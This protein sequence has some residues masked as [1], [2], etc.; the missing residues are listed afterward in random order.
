LEAQ[1][2]IGR[3][4]Q[5]R[6]VDRVPLLIVVA[7]RGLVGGAFAQIIHGPAARPHGAPIAQVILR[8]VI[9]MDGVVQSQKLCIGSVTLFTTLFMVITMCAGHFAKFTVMSDGIT[10]GITDGIFHH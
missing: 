3:I 10:D 7:G 6:L 1:V 4:L 2:R 9:I 8:F 5:G